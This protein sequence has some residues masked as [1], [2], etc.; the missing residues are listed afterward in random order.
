L[1]VPKQGV[2]LAGEHGKVA[3]SWEPVDGAESYV[4]E[5]DTRDESGWIFDR[6]HTLRVIP[7]RETSTVLDVTGFARVRWRVYAVPRNGQPGMASPWMELEG[8]PFT[9]IYK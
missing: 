5:W 7:V 1:A 2:P 9:K 8:A 4:V 6:D 3:L